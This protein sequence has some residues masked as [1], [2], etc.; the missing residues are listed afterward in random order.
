MR[1]PKSTH[2]TKQNRPNITI[3]V[4]EIDQRQMTNREA[5]TLGNPLSLGG[6]RRPL[7]GTVRASDGNV[8]AA[9]ETGTSSGAGAQAGEQT[10]TQHS[11]LQETPKCAAGEEQL[12]HLGVPAEAPLLTNADRRHPRR[13]TTR[14]ALPAPVCL[15]RHL[16]TRLH[17]H[18]GAPWLLT[19]TSPPPPPAGPQGGEHPGSGLPQRWSFLVERKFQSAGSSPTEEKC[20]MK[21]YFWM[22]PTHAFICAL[23]TPGPTA[24]AGPQPGHLWSLEGRLA[25][26][27]LS[28]ASPQRQW[29]LERTSG[30][31]SN[32]KLTL[33]APFLCW[34][35]AD[36]GLLGW[37]KFKLETPEVIQLFSV[38][39][40][41]SEK[42][43]RQEV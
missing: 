18:T 7:T 11:R 40:D 32:P 16:C 17:V 15:W 4:L 9:L 34:M 23:S 41:S 30:S 27:V 35:C 39:M 5:L 6:W 21:Q 29:E 31:T 12:F 1:S 24:R 25:V 8:G 19:E 22:G 43:P 28:R 36:E 3:R 26:S 38:K 42:N 14:S 10:G 2:E 13:W 33:P 37:R 20:K